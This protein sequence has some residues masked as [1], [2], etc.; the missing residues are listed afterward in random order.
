MALEDFETLLTSVVPYKA[1]SKFLHAD[2]PEMLPYLQMVHL[3][4]LYQDDQEILTE[5]ER[6]LEDQTESSELLGDNSN[7][8]DKEIESQRKQ[9]KKRV[10]EAYQISESN[11]MIFVPLQII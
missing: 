1:F 8:L 9:L 10:E 7:S 3:C 5:L 11:K 4:K 2:H 6:E